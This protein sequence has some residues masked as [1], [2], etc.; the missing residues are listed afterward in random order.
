MC[1]RSKAVWGY[2]EAFLR[3]CR[4]VLRLAPDLVTE[5]LAVV[6]EVNRRLVGV[7][8][9]SIDA[10]TAELDLLFIEPTAQRSGVGR[11]LYDWAV[12]AAAGRGATTLGILADPGAR[13]FYE[14]M[15]AVW[16]REAPSDVIAGRT[17]PWL[18]HRLS[19]ASGSQ[20]E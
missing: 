12:G 2:D 3:Q 16:Q 9:V 8:Q 19:S 13:P 17:L 5:G 14:R 7:A 15:G 1:I 4:S 10:E 11:R 20:I 18:E 6:A